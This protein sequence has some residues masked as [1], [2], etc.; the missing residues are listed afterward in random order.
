VDRLLGLYERLAEHHG[1]RFA[2]RSAGDPRLRGHLEAR[3]RD[4]EAAC[5]VAERQGDLHGFC[6]VAVTRRPAF[7]VETERLEVEAVFVRPEQ[8]RG[9]V[10]RAL[11]EAAF[12]ELDP[13]R[14]LR[15]ELGVARGNAEG[16]GFW[17][18]LGFCPVMDVLE[19]RR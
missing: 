17:R 12:A 4:P 15:V 19:R 6:L 16:D 9:G 10:A 11:V 8:R 5:M 1:P 3:L 18:A 14:R 13:A 2:L 7:F